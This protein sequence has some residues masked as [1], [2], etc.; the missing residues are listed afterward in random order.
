MAGRDSSAGRILGEIASL[1]EEKRHADCY[2]LEQAGVYGLISTI[3]LAK[4]MHIHAMDSIY[5][6]PYE[7]GPA[8][9]EFIADASV[10]VESVLCRPTRLQ[11]SSLSEKVHLLSQ[12]MQS[13]SFAL[14]KH[15]T[16]QKRSAPPQQS[17]SQKLTVPDKSESPKQ[18]ATSLQSKPISQTSP[19]L[20]SPEVP[21]EPKTSPA[22]KP[23]SQA[24]AP[25]V[26]PNTESA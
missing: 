5:R 13:L 25:Q 20:K 12:E 10:V 8:I 3:E 18:T 19:E 15:L 7:K 22:R 6:C 21:N 16:A 17:T 11:P 2:I 4:L 23:E 24:T 1:D 26:K 9:E 14:E